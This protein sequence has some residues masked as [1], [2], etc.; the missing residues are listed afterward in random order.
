MVKVTADV[1]NFNECLYIIFWTTEYDCFIVSWQ[2][3]HVCGDIVPGL[4]TNNY[5][6]F[7]GKYYMFVEI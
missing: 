6:L 2:V 5:L 1:H 4:L 7:Q 3:L